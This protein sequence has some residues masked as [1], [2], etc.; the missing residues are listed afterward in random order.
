MIIKS[1]R[2][3]KLWTT[4]H[5]DQA[6]QSLNT[7]QYILEVACR[8]LFSE[9]EPFNKSSKIQVDQTSYAAQKLFRFQIVY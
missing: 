9:R 2:H 4:R 8:I 6:A 3:N 7:E 1:D 5:E